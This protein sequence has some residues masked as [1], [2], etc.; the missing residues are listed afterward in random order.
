MT[1][2]D[3]HAV[4]TATRGLKIESPEEGEVR[5][6]VVWKAP[7]PRARAQAKQFYDEQFGN[8]MGDE[9]KRAR[10]D[11]LCVVARVDDAIVA[12][13]T[14]EISPSPDLWVDVAWF[15]CF[16]H[17]RHRRRGVAT[18][19]LRRARATLEGWSKE[20]AAKRPPKT[21]VVDEAL[22]RTRDETVFEDGDDDAEGAS[23]VAFGIRVEKAAIGVA[24]ET[25][26]WPGTGLSLVG[27]TPENLQVRLSWFDHAKVEY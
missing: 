6:E 26:H 14:V 16:V 15:R 2:S 3:D 23:C 20:Q 21:T 17:P 10:L 8:A 24:G 5:Y 13:S 11:A 4:T 1:M 22:Y 7:N 19:L 25:P 12:V 18:H 9:N 27:Y